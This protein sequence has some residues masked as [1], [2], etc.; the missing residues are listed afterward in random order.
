MADISKITLPNGSEYNIKDSTAR[1]DSV[2]S[3]SISNTGLVTFKNSSGTAL[4]TLQLPL[5]NGGV[6]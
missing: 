2:K 3:A 5:Y 6:N 1:T 4:F